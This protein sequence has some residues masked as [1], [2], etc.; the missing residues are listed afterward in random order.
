MH[1]LVVS[2]YF[3]P[4]PFRINDM[5]KEWVKRGYEVTVVTGI[6]NYP[7]GR[8][9]KGYGWLK[10]RKETVDGISI[11]RLPLIARGSSKIGLMLNYASFMISGRIFARFTKIKADKVFIFEV[12]PMTQAFAGTVYAKKRHVP[13]TIYVQDLWP[14][15]LEAVARIK[16]KHILNAVDRMV[17]RVYKDCDH[18]LATSPS[19]KTHL[20]KRKSVYDTEGKSKVHYWPQYAE[21]FYKPLKDAERPSDFPRDENLKIAFTGNVGYAQGLQILP[22]VAK[23]LKD[24][25]LKVDFVIIGDGR[26]MPEFKAETEK[27]QV[28]EYFYFLGRKAATEI[29]KY[30][31]YSDAG[32]ISFAEDEIFN[33]TIPA[34]LQSYMACGKMILASSGG[35]TKRVIEDAK[36]GVATSQGDAD[37]LA[38]AISDLLNKDSSE[39]KQYGDRAY[40]YASKAYSKSALMD[41]FE[42]IV[43]EAT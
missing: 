16:N 27:L 19:F 37:A 41:S 4:E 11:I 7:E 23:I 25:K 24:K 8:F 10:K 35:E 3:Y 18:I 20:E 38:M 39:I 6:P 28:G 1:I 29:P 14:E 33:M 40:E 12:S 17:D 15:N 30:L 32:F 42:E 36:C 43:S 2:Q 22:K 13:C 26:Y 34:K 21:D 9:Y 5:C 31:A